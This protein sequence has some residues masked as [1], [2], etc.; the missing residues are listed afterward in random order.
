[1][2]PTN[3]LQ[4][5][6]AFNEYTHGFNATQRPATNTNRERPS[7]A[8][9]GTARALSTN[10][11]HNLGVKATVKQY[12]SQIENAGSMTIRDKQNSNSNL[13]YATN[14]AFAQSIAPPKP[15]KKKGPFAR[16]DQVNEKIKIQ[17]NVRD[18]S[19]SSNDEASVFNNTLKNKLDG[20]AYNV[21]DQDN[22]NNTG[23]V[24]VHK[25]DRVK[26]GFNVSYDS[27]S[28]QGIKNNLFKQTAAGQNH[29]G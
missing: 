28:F 13:N 22:L 1:M 12:G 11:A 26:A 5:N 4:P 18:T 21:D 24:N 23:S 14:Q 9:K 29:Q 15:A 6:L 16:F 20:F 8:D 19:V 27:N 2:T 25:Y 17:V 7:N 3:P 10:A